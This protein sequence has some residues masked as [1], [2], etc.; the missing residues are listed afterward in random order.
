M[1][2]ESKE[3]FLS[4]EV[5]WKSE[6]LSK[7]HGVVL[8]QTGGTCIGPIAY[9]ISLILGII[10]RELPITSPFRVNLWPGEKSWV[11]L[12]GFCC[13]PVLFFVYLSLRNIGQQIG[14][15]K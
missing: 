6:T 14:K 8:R 15:M 2:E 4:L 5:F 12:G 1:P 9:R 10:G 13:C 7:S 3:L 11:F